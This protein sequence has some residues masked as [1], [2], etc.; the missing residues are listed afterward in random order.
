MQQRSEALCCRGCGKTIDSATCT[1]PY[2]SGEKAARPNLLSHGW[3]RKRTPYPNGRPGVPASLRMFTKACPPSACRPDLTQAHNDKAKD[4]RGVQQVELR[5]DAAF[6]DGFLSG[7][8]LWNA[9]HGAQAGARIASPADTK[10]GS[11]RALSG[12]V[13]VMT[14]LAA[15]ASLPVLSR[16][17]W[18]TIGACRGGAQGLC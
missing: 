9:L 7:A 11:P 3:P 5:V 2:V 17:S 8:L 13:E 14:P 1:R 4:C 10:L 18:R 15:C 12:I 16:T 6:L